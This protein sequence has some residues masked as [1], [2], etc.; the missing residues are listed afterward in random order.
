MTSIRVEN[1]TKFTDERGIT[2]RT[3]VSVTLGSR[4]KPEKRDYSIPDATVVN[5]WDP[6]A[7]DT[8]NPQSFSF[9]EIWADGLVH[10]EFT[11]DDGGEVGKVVFTLPVI[12]DL[13][14][15]L[16][17][18]ASFAN[19]GADDAF[20]GTLDLIERIRIKNLSGATRKVQVRIAE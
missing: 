7:T 16:G 8:E 3:P 1:L 2:E 5:C 10:V 15:Q 6:L 13:K 12:A 9:L 11:V 14:F 4:S 20:S 17:S 18:D 19:P